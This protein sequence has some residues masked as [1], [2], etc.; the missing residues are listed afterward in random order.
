MSR[1]PPALL[2]S[3]PL[4]ET[5]SCGT[6]PDGPRNPLLS[7]SN[8]S[9]HRKDPKHKLMLHFQGFCF[10]PQTESLSLG[11]QPWGSLGE[12]SAGE[13]RW[14]ERGLWS[15]VLA[16]PYSVKE[17]P[18]GLVPSIPGHRRPAWVGT[19]PGT[20]NEPPG[21]RQETASG[22]ARRASLFITRAFP[23]GAPTPALPGPALPRRTCMEM[24]AGLQ[25]P[26]PGGRRRRSVK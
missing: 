1:E 5:A 25:H 13:G 20:C 23:P 10:K 17:G 16:S 9:F 22:H 26:G 18:W 4:G 6:S 21:V 3:W 14:Q 15:L 19:L 11:I 24:E 7:H 12:K 8:K 2:P